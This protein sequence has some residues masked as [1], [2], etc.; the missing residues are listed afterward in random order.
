MDR[1]PAWIYTVTPNGSDYDCQLYID[2]DLNLLRVLDQVTDSAGNKFGVTK[3]FNPL[4]LAQNEGDSLFQDG[5]YVTL[6]SLS[7]GA[8]APVLDPD[9]HSFVETPVEL[10]PDFFPD[11]AWLTTPTNV[12]A[13]SHPAYSYDMDLAVED[14]SDY[15]AGNAIAGDYLVD[16]VGNIYEILSFDANSAIAHAH[17]RELFDLNQAPLAESFA[18]VYRPK[19]GASIINQASLEFLGKTAEDRV[20]NIDSVISWNHRGVKLTANAVTIDNVTKL[21]LSGFDI[22]ENGTGWQG[23]KTV[24]LTAKPGYEIK[25]GNGIAVPHDK[26]V[27][28]NGTGV[29]ID[30]SGAQTFI[31]INT[32]EDIDIQDKTIGTPTDGTYSDGLLNFEDL[33]TTADAVDGINKMLGLLAP[34]KPT[35]LNDCT[36]ALVGTTYVAREAGLGII[37]API[38]GSM[39]PEAQVDR[40]FYNG[41]AGILSA[42]IDGALVGTIPLDAYDNSGVN[43]AL[44]IT[45]DADPYAGQFGKQGFWKQ[46]TAKIS[47]ASN[48]A[49]GQHTYQLDHSDTGSVSEQFYIDNAVTPAVASKSII[50]HTAVGKKVSSIPVFTAGDTLTI[51]ASITSAVKKYYNQTRI[52]NLSGPQ[53]V[54]A[55][56]PLPGTPPSTGA[57][58]TIVGQNISV[59][60]GAFS[61]NAPINVNAYSSSDSLFAT[62]QLLGNIRVDAVSNESL[63]KK[64]GTGDYPAVFGAGY[65]TSELL[66]A[67]EE[68]QVENG[69]YK[70]P[71]AVDYSANRLPGPNYLAI[72]GAFRWATF[73]LTPSFS[74]TGFTFNINGSNITATLG[75]ISGAKV[76]AKVQGAT[77]WID[78]NAA[79]PGVGNPQSDGD[80]ALAPGSNATTKIITFGSQV[81]T[82]DLYVRIGLPIGSTKKFTGIS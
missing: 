19:G 20:R 24:T 1:T 74:G 79:Y 57:V 7:T 55:D 13:A 61:V 72:S 25:D 80:A 32:P 28:I 63:R 53:F 56:V 65:D 75:I 9:W 26:P 41:D 4:D 14:P 68:L 29:I 48:L 30:S 31:T 2:G 11:I 67:N 50:A 18:F 71:P 70:Y 45:S 78:C 15:G 33:T 46:L 62:S 37:R 16:N 77:G 58:I 76:F 35:I 44:V 81:R 12:V 73:L 40:A 59:A 17:V 54:S 3:F 38:T 22:A 42:H 6:K 66:T 82:G 5:W 21:D 51:A 49:V 34:A 47:P 8:P 27:I 43:G 64:S 36:L 69:E 23:G 52:V 10:R 60:A 39:K